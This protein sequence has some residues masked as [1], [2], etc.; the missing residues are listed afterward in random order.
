MEGVVLGRKG[1][2]VRTELGWSRT[3]ST[4]EASG[5]SASKA[6]DL[7]ASQSGDNAGLRYRGFLPAK[8][9]MGSRSN[10]GREF[11]S[12]LLLNGNSL[13]LLECRSHCLIKM[14]DTSLHPF[15]FPRHFP[16]LK[17]TV[18]NHVNI[19]KRHLSLSII[20]S[21]LVLRYSRQGGPQNTTRRLLHVKAM[22]TRKNAHK[23]IPSSQTEL[24]KRRA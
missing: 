3:R 15:L 20:L 22:N 11:L 19:H 21:G 24:L 4:V 7:M 9:G 18:I 14:S 5:A 17:Q 8:E 16:S 12:P 23:V 6:V 10:M 1:Q 2:E 13:Q